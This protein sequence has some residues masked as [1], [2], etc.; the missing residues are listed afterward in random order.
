MA[1]P[2]LACWMWGAA[3]PESLAVLR[4]GAIPTFHS[5]EAAVRT[6]GHLWRHTDN[7]HHLTEINAAMADRE[8]TS[9]Q[10]IWRL[11][12]HARTAVTSAGASDVLPEAEVRTLLAAYG[13][14]LQLT[15]L[16]ANE[17]EAVEAA[18]AAGYPVFVE[19]VASNLV[20]EDAG[21]TVR[22]GA[23]DSDEVCRIVRALKLL[24]RE[25]FG[26]N[27]PIL[28]AVRPLVP[29]TALELAVSCTADRE[30]GPVIRLGEGGRPGE[31][32]RH[33]VK[34]LAPL[35]PF[36]ARE[37][38]LQ[39]TVLGAGRARCGKGS[40]T[41]RVGDEP[42]D[43]DALGRFLLGLSWLAVEQPRIKEITINPLLVWD[44]NAIAG[45][46]RVTLHDPATEER[47]LPRPLVMGPF[48][49]REGSFRE[50][51]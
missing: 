44:G 1:K 46:V 11:E 40:A 16:A 17:G 2:V 7:L 22:L 6:F 38:I 25:R 24:I 28:M 3:S 35:T 4:G 31:A 47:H 34:A 20:E 13:L 49:R 48:H 21:E 19:L 9:L 36:N 12:S 14:P 27:A 5:P 33:A 41:P 45:D 32:P 10:G 8:V 30:M 15:A 29:P 18:D 39:G 50:P 51:V 42:F 43:L 37:L 23:D 26:T